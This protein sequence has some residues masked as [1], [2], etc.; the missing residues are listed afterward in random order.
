MLIFFIH[1]SFTAFQGCVQRSPP[2]PPCNLHATQMKLSNASPSLVYHLS[3]SQKIRSSFRHRS[4][5]LL[6]PVTP[7]SSSPVPSS[8]RPLQGRF[9]GLDFIPGATQSHPAHHVY[10]RR[11]AGT[12]LS[13]HWSSSGFTLD[14]G[15]L[16]RLFPQPETF[17]HML[18]GEISLPF[19]VAECPLWLVP[20]PPMTKRV[21]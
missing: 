14:S 2:F 11:T 4:W 9:L 20:K 12:P 15:S 10:L 18:P 6:P 7:P 16:H 13:P 1:P 5:L 21:T 3:G 8:F 17:L 19:A